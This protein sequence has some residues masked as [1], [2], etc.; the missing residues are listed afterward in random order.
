MPD[1]GTVR[2]ILL[3][4]LP[5]LFWV[6]YLRSLS[7]GKLSPWWHWAVA[8]AAGWA[9]TEVTLFLSD[10]WG[11]GRLQLL[12]QVGSLVYFVVGVGLV[13]EGSKALCALLFLKIPGFCKQPLLG[14]QLCGGVALGFATA[15]NFVYAVNFGEGV[16]VGRFV[17]STLAH[18]LFASVWGF[19]LGSRTEKVGEVFIQ[20]TSWSRFGK[21]LFLSALG[22]GLFDWFL[23]T[24]RPILAV[25]TLVLLWFGFREAVLGAFLRQEYSRGVAQVTVRC[26]D[27]AVL[28]RAN[29]NYCSFCGQ[30]LSHQE[31]S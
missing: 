23:M 9:S 20:R 12:P 17:F 6:V 19:T 27:C 31:S 25:L 2:T 1:F 3:S 14:L 10:L 5:G 30:P 29:G 22:H 16:L 11:V 18:V 8:L 7:R 24:G 15:E 4:L 28:T 13:E 21:Y 26:P